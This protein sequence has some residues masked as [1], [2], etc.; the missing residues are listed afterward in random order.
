V[1][2]RFK[3]NVSDSR[4]LGV[5]T[6]EIEFTPRNLQEQCSL[7]HKSAVAMLVIGLASLGGTYKSIV[8]ALYRVRL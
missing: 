2:L 8:L 7:P 1:I 6:P 4:L 3:R 5:L